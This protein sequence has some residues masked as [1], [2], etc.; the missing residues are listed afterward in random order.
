MITLYHCSSARS[1][2]P[3]WTLE[4]MGL[5]CE[6][7]M[8]PFPPRALAKEYLGINPLGTIPFLIDGDTRMS[9]SAAIS[10]YLVERHGPSPMAVTKDEPA[11]GAYLNFLHLGEATLTVPQT[12]VLRYTHL[13]PPERRLP[14]AVEDYRIVFHGRLK[15]LEPLLER[16][17]FL[18]A[19]RFTA[20]DVSVGYALLLAERLGLDEGFTPAV[21]AYWARLQQ[22]DGYRRAMARQA[23]AAAEQGVAVTPHRRG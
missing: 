18:C 22:R 12:I 6:L 10:Q 14:Q 5:P 2:R 16:E 9:E 1:F 3:L 17:E 7:K 11:F 19:G 23:Q 20:A 21:R 15:K 4:E 13:E 8:L